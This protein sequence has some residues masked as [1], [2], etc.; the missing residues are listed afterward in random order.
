MVDVEVIK[1]RL[2]QLST[3]INKIEWIDINPQNMI[4][5]KKAR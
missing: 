4:Y 1:Q 5:P 2:N 3:S